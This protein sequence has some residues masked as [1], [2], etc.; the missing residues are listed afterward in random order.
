[1]T[2]S[3]HATTTDP[4]VA[5]RE[6]ISEITA[7]LEAIRFRLLGVHASLPPEGLAAEMRTVIECVL[8]DAFEPAL[9]D[10]RAAVDDRT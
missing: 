5:A 3:R 10:L 8:A 9:R 7:E 2:T 1:M 6:Q 4:E